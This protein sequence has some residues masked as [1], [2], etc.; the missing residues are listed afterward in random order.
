MRPDEAVAAIQ[1][2]RTQG[3]D[4][5]RDEERVA[6]KRAHSRAQTDARAAVVRMH[7]EDYRALYQAARIAR[8]ADEGL[9]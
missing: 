5:M 6:R 9:T 1:A 2:T 7:A 3:R 4:R 8:L